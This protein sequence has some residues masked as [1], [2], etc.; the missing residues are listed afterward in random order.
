MWVG[1]GPRKGRVVVVDPYWDFWGIFFRDDDLTPPGR[2][3][4]NSVQA[5]IPI[6]KMPVYH[7][8]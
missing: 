1:F 5:Q 8:I 2:M 4:Q 3:G 7:D 6:R